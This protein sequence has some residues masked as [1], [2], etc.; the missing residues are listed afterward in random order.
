MNVGPTRPRIG[1]SW[2]ALPPSPCINSMERSRHNGSALPTLP[3]H[4]TW[5]AR[6]G[7]A[8]NAR[9]NSSSRPRFCFSINSPIYANPRFVV[10]PGGQRICRS[11]RNNRSSRSS[12]NNRGNRGN[13]NRA[14]DPLLAPCPTMARDPPRDATVEQSGPHPR[15]TPPRPSRGRPGPCGTLAA[16]MP[17]PCHARAAADVAGAI[18]RAARRCPRRPVRLEVLAEVRRELQRPPELMLGRAR[19]KLGPSRAS[20]RHLLRNAPWAASRMLVGGDSNCVAAPKLRALC[21]WVSSTCSGTTR[22]CA[23]LSP[24]EF[25]VLV[26]VQPLEHH[27]DLLGEERR[28]EHTNNNTTNNTIQRRGRTPACARSESAYTA[29]TCDARLGCDEERTARGGGNPQKRCLPTAG[30]GD[31]PPDLEEKTTPKAGG[32]I[33]THSDAKPSCCAPDDPWRHQL[34]SGETSMLGEGGRVG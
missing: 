15:V 8:T 4:S 24:A 21:C 34:G 19:A 20:E 3:V 28:W 29:R 16:P 32:I 30:L 33:P 1:Q 10:H 17:R 11:S 22:E 13:R 2:R 9:S 7:A 6:A 5:S 12:R 25:A 31:A 27:R 23:H 18:G 14:P 26:H